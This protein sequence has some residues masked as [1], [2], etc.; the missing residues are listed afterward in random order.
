MTT[1]AP[2][3]AAVSM[4]RSLC[5]WLCMWLCIWLCGI[6]QAQE[7]A[8]AEVG[9]VERVQAP[10]NAVFEG[11]A[12]SLEPTAPVYYL[13][14]LRTGEAARLRVALAD[15]STITM[16]EKAELRVDEL[17]YAPGRETEATLNLIKGALLF[18]G[19]KLRASERR[20]VLIRTPVAILGVRGTHVWYGPIDGAIGVLVVEGEVLVSNPT[21]RVTLRAGEG[22]TI[23]PNGAL[24]PAKTWGAGKVERALDMVAFD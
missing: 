1:H 18:I 13:D 16:G 10:A 5:M 3:M 23:Q 22:T 2:A 15:A 6:A 20:R 11:D 9:A 19:D 24:S 21:G 8:R 4:V 12:R 14:L 7:T 17:V